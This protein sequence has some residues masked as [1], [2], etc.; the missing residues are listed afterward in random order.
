MPLGTSHQTIATGAVFVPEVWSQKVV[1][2]VEQ[3]LVMAPLVD[4]FDDD[5]K[6]EGDV[7]HIPGVS[8][9]T[10]NT[11]LASTQVTLNAPTEPEDTITVNQHKECSFLIEDI[12]KI[13]AKPN[14]L[15]KYTNK[16]GYAIS[17]NVD[18][19]LIALYAGAGES[20]GG[21]GAITKAVLINA[22]R[23][24]NSNAVPDTE[25]YL[26]ISPYAAAQI[27]NISGLTE[28]QSLGESRLQRP[29]KHNKIGELFGLEIF[30]TNQ[31]VSVAGTPTVD[32]NLLFHREAFGLAMQATPRVQS[33]YVLEYLGNL[34]VVDVLYGYN[35]IRPEFA[36]DVQSGQLAVT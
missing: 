3:N 20:A 8:N 28:Y 29:I 15:S 16:A 32:H 6:D 13:Q 25:R 24:L 34:T 23:V 31:I 27:T 17:A 26:V 21:T 5:V 18:S 1:V 22:V 19:A 9:L 36:V 14:Y 30:M 7:I 4:R 12:L 35:T 10:V 2:A 11:K 33:Q